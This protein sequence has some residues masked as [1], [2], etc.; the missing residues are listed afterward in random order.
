MAARACAS[1]LSMRL[2]IGGDVVLGVRPE[3]FFDAGQGD[4]DITIKADVAEHLGSVSYVYAKAGKEELIIEREASRHRANGDRPHGVHQGR[5]VA[6]LRRHR[7]HGFADP[8]PDCPRR[9]QGDT[10]MNASSK[11]I[12]WGILGPGSIAKAFAGGLAHSR[13]GHPRRPSARAI[14][15][16]PASPRAF[17]GARILDGYDALLARSGRRRDLHF[18]AASEPRRM[19]DQ[20]GGS[21]QARALREAACAYRLRGR[22]DDPCGAQGRHL[23][24]R[25][26]HVPAAPADAQ[27]W[28][29]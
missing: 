16:R 23:S 24:R 5:P 3:H 4:C 10:E 9:L 13:T 2:P 18:D 17:P 12:R 7:R 20:G 28:S 22:R 6:P 29:N 11:K 1:R 27:S 25:S 26:L 19:G 14:P 21:R 15:A 8:F